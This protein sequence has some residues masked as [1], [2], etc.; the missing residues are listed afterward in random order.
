MANMTYATVFASAGFAG[1]SFD[2]GVGYN[3]SYSTTAGDAAF[4]AS[5]KTI[6][7]TTGTWPTWIREVGKQF[8]VSGTAS[9][10]GA[11]TVVSVDGT[12]KV[13][14][15]LE[16][17]VDETPAGVSAF[18]GSANTGIIDNL[19]SAGNGILTA[20]APLVLSCSGALG[21]ARTLSIA[22]LEAETAQEGNEPLRGRFFY[23]NVRNSDVSS[24]NSLTVSSSATINGQ[25]SLAIVNP[26]DYMFF[27]EGA[28]AWRCNVLP[29][30]EEPLATLK[31]VPFTAAMWAA[32][33]ANEITIIPS[34]SPAAGQAGPHYLTV[35]SN[36]V[37]QVVNTDLNPDE[38][39]DVEVQF[40]SSG[41][42]TLVKAQGAKAFN[43]VAIIVGALD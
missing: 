5:G 29:R 9:N 14:T 22:A 39:V 26:G 27:F 4:L 34:G 12:F 21:A 8:V 33:T 37:V 30:P 1:E 13:L 2:I 18:D 24:T 15:V 23:L 43:G 31:R 38:I 17:L 10:D 32:G 19:L 41:N 36:Y 25:A 11:Y 40:D 3:L 6:T 7:L 20:D 28:G 42:I 35:A 16:T